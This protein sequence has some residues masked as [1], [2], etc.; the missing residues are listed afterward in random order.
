MELFSGWMF[1]AQSDPKCAKSPTGSQLMLHDLL[2]LVT[3]GKIR[4][5]ETYKSA[6]NDIQMD[7]A[8][9]LLD[10]PHHFLVLDR[11][12]EITQLLKSLSFLFI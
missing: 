12:R 3:F 9:C 5:S 2:F 1:S 4:N 8:R 10:P 7:E 6:G 11:N